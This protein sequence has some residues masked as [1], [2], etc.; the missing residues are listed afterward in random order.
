M[1]KV[2]RVTMFQCSKCKKLYE[3]EESAQVC[4]EL[5][6]LIKEPNFEPLQKLITDH[7]K[8]II[9]G[10]PTKDIEHWCY[11]G[12]FVTFYGHDIFNWISQKRMY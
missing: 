11:E 7:L 5:P 10:K 2:N 1:T 4:C 8:D 3:E 12:V 6:K 9:D